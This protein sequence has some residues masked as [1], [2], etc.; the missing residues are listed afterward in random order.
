MVLGGAAVRQRLTEG[1]A[2]HSPAFLCSRGRQGAIS[3]DPEGLIAKVVS[4]LAPT[5]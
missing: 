1:R 4:A 3:I 2:F 5:D